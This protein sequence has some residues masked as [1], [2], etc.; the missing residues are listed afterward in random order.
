MSRPGVSKLVL[1]PKVGAKRPRSSFTPVSTSFSQAILNQPAVP[2]FSRYQPRDPLMRAQI[3]PDTLTE[4]ARR[5]YGFLLYFNRKNSKHLQLY[6][7]SLETFLPALTRDDFIAELDYLLSKYLSKEW[8]KNPAQSVNFATFTINGLIY[9][10]PQLGSKLHRTRK[11]ITGWKRAV[12]KSSTVAIPWPLAVLVAV[13]LVNQNKFDLGVGVLLAHHCMLRVDELV[14]ITV[15]DIEFD[16]QF[17]GTGGAGVRLERTKTGRNKYAKIED[18]AILRLVRHL[19][20]LRRSSIGPT[21]KLIS[22]GRQSFRLYFK[23]ACQFL[24]FSSFNFSPHSLRA[25]GATALHDQGMPVDKIMHRGRWTQLK[26]LN[27]YIQSGR[28]I[29]IQYQAKGR[30]ECPLK[31]SSDDPEYITTLMIHLQKQ[32]AQN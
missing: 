23:Q 21:A 11:R 4:Y 18:K 14:R 24:N 16:S 30:T 31:L 10:Q 3:Q 2:I 1:E 32:I 27:T 20:E 5:T 12:P 9:F 22:V 29:F 7:E 25:G 15:E 17:S 28:S 6:L 26:S 8:K 19:V 13:T